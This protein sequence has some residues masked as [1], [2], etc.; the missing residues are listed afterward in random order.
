M[1]QTHMRRFSLEMIL[2]GCVL[3]GHSV[4]AVE[5]KLPPLL[6]EPTVVFKAEAFP[7]GKENGTWHFR[8]WWEA[9]DGVLLRNDLPGGGISASLSRSRSTRMLLFG[10]TS[11]FAGQKRSGW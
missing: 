5:M 11:S 9:R 2:F 10:L 3:A 1:H 4:N 8:E 6:A 7:K